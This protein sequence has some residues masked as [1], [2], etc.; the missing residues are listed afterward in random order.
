VEG[1]GSAREEEEEMSQPGSQEALET[2]IRQAAIRATDAAAAFRVLDQEWE[3]ERR[4]AG[5]ERW[6]ELKGLHSLAF[7]QLCAADLAQ[8]VA[9]RLLREYHDERRPEPRETEP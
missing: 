9:V 1:R 8:A 2:A 5:V 4:G 6:L 3:S 7:A